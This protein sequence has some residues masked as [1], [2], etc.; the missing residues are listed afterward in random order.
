M[1][2]IVTELQLPGKISFNYEDL[3]RELAEKVKEYSSLVYT[4]A[5]IQEAKADRANLNRLKKALND[6]RI[7]QEREFMKP[8]D[9]F[10]AQVR[11]LCGI[12]DSASSAID[13]Q[14]K[15][16]EDAQKQKKADEIKAYW[17]S[18]DTPEWMRRD[19]PKWLNASYTMKAIAAEIDGLL[20]Q[21]QKDMD[22]LD[23]MGVCFEAVQKYQT[24][25]DLNA[26]LAEDS[27]IKAQAEERRKW[28]E[29]H[30]QAQIP[31]D[32]SCK[33]VES[34]TLEVSPERENIRP[35]EETGLARS[36][37]GFQAYLTI[38]EALELKKYFR[39]RGIKFEAL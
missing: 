3:K 35:T 38:P 2:L 20:L 6:E 34:P 1:K 27:R 4:E 31:M 36:W 21:I 15:A 23:G 16:F 9:E 19:N 37:V 18:K 7:R 25:L 12:V 22:T 13:T 5:Q 17:D 8:F 30:A 28:E 14:V 33:A 11:E 26:A 24:T 39:E 10:K 29:D 32:T